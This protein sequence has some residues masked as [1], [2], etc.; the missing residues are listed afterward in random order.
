MGLENLRRKG[1][2][3]SRTLKIKVPGPLTDKIQ[4]IQ[5]AL[6]RGGINKKFTEV[7]LE[8]ADEGA[9]AFEQSEPQ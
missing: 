2:L 4:R 6:K 3:K 9:K 5:A 8:L 1:A 7:L